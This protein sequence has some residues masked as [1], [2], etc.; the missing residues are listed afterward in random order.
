MRPT[1]AGGSSL[2]NVTDQATPALA[3][4]GI[5]TDRKERAQSKTGRDIMGGA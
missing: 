5:H 4:S 2:E 3:V 1:K